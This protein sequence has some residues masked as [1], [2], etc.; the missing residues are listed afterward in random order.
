MGGWGSWTYMALMLVA[1][2]CGCGEPTRDTPP[3]RDRPP[4]EWVPVIRP[5]AP[6]PP[7][8][9]VVPMLDALEPPYKAPPPIQRK[10][11]YGD[12]STAY[13][14]RPDRDPN[15]MCRVTGG[16][17][18]MGG[19]PGSPHAVA[20][21]TRVDDFDIDQFEVTV[22]QA[23]LFLNAHGNECPGFERLANGD[24]T[25][26]MLFDVQRTVLRRNGRFVA[27]EGAELTAAQ[28]FSWEG[29]M[30]YCQWVGKD[31]PSLAQWEYAARHDPRA[32]RD[33][34]YP[35]GD[36]WRPRH[37][38]CGVP[39]LCQ[40]PDARD[41]AGA[42]VGIFDGTR[43]NGDGSSPWGVH[44]MMGGEVELATRCDEPNATC[45]PGLPCSCAR[46]EVGSVFAD[47][48]DRSVAAHVEREL[49][50]FQGLRCARRRRVSD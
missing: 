21:A 46:F 5:D 8:P 40:L 12:C 32:R 1:Q 7:D 2:L 26:C 16:T 42:F 48:D 25:P 35:W 19:A 18:Q 38:W 3:A 31:V 28:D 33:L 13:A 30:R 49:H 44:D 39:Q 20:V 36:Q 29:A 41:S 14:P 37:V 24:A 27:A 23:A 9:T 10:H 17:F 43:G 45:R 47:A 6:K 34:R 11:R 50:S 15:P 22:Q 4:T